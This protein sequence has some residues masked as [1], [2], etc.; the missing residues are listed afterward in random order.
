MS[1]KNL[2]EAFNQVRENERIAQKNYADAVRKIRNPM[3]K[4]LFQQLSEFA[5]CNYD[6]L[7]VLE[8]SLEEQGTFIYYERK[9]FPLPPKVETKAARGPNQK[10][11]MKIVSEAMELEHQAKKAYADLAAQLVDS[12]GRKMFT[13]L[14]EEKHDHYRILKEAYWTLNNLGVWMWSC[15]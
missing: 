15:P 12:R 6:Q 1:T 14:S 7:V 13:D 3:G 11:V 4:F 8:K 2:P 9:E 10:S 5:Q